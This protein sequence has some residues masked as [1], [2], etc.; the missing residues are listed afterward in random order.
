MYQKQID[1]KV[2]DLRDK[3][4]LPFDELYHKEKRL[5]DQV[6]K[7]EEELKKKIK[8]LPIPLG[9]NTLFNPDDIPQDIPMNP[10]L[11]SEHQFVRDQ[12]D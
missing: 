5:V 2:Q 3:F 8:S 9:A 10:L 12:R 4:D 7:A 1:A 11:K 6:V